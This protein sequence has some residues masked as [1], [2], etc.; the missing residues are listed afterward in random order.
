MSNESSPSGP[1]TIASGKFLRLV[2]KGTWEWAERTNAKGVVVIVAVTAEGNL[3]LVE[4][5]RVPIGGSVIEFPAGLAGDEAGAENEDLSVAAARE[6]EE[7]TGYRPGRM[8]WLTTGPVSAGMSGEVLTF[9][10]G[11]GLVRVGKG[12]GVEGENITVHEIPVGE[13]RG[14][15]ARRH[16]EG[17]MADPKV[18]AGLYFLKE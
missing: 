17:V 4:Q 14:W 18:Y 7:E 16:E 6:L 15:L 2:R 5:H 11:H 1:E 10:R 9:F 8:E 3:L 13:A 12:G